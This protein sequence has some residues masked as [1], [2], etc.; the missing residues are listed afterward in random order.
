MVDRIRTEL[1]VLV[2]GLQIAGVAI[3]RLPHIVTFTVTGV[4]GEAL[5][6]ELDRRGLAVASGS[7]CTSDARMPSQVLAAMG[8]PATASVRASLPLGCTNRTID[9]FLAALPAA[10][11]AVRGI[12]G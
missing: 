4:V 9:D 5:V 3:D 6:T 8:L 12:A 2:D 1:P 11:A 10:V 7:A